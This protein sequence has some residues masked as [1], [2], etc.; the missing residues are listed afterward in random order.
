MPRLYIALQL[1]ER[2]QEDL[3][4]ISTGL[5][6]AEW[7]YSEDYHLTLRF[8]GD[9][10]G[11]GFETIRE[12]LAGIQ[13][14]SFLLELRG[15]GLFPL[16]GDPETLWAGVPKNEGLLRLR[17]RIESLLARRGVPADTR[18]FHPH[19]TLAKVKNAA[20]EWIGQ[21]IADHALFSIPEI[22]I[23][24]FSLFSSRLTPE[25]AIHDLEETY[26]LNGLL[27]PDAAEQ[28]EA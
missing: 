7:V 25:G 13:A 6:G 17:H 22:P 20:V 14:D 3:A 5:P 4:R 23:Q 2:V 11:A 16:R 19:V 9:V 21:Y 8:I 1:P 10:D 28:E 27:E 12:G 18:K 26:P 15:V 24:S